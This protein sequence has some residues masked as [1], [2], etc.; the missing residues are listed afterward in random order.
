MSKGRTLK[1]VTGTIYLPFV[2]FVWYLS[3]ALFP[4][5][6]MFF[7]C[8]TSIITYPINNEETRDAELNSAMQGLGEM[9]YMPFAWYIDFIK[10]KSNE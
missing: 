8:L 2:A 1:V 10:L 3:M 5:P 9:L 4:F 7:I 6:L